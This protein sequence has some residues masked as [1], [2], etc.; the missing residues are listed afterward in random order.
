MLSLR[1]LL[2]LALIF[3]G[4]LVPAPALRAQVVT[5]KLG[6]LAPEGSA[7]HGLLKEMAE[8]WSKASDGKVKLKIYPGGVSGNE[9]DTVRKM[10]VGQLQA[11]ALS[12]VGLHDIENS[13]QAIAT[14][15]LLTS[16]D[17]WDYVYSKM[18]PVWD[19]R[20]AAKGFVPLMWGDIGWIHL[21]FKK[22]VRNPSQFKGT[23]MFAW[24][25][26]PASVEAWKMS[27]FQPV[28]ISSTD[29]LPS[30]STGMIDGFGANPPMAFLSRWY[31]HARF[32][33]SEPWGHLPIGTVV[34][35]ETWEKI[36]ADLR[37]K[38]LEIAREFGVRVNAETGKLYA[39]A[40]AQ[41]KK[42]GLKVIDLDENEKKA[43]N[44]AAEK[45][46]PAVRGGVVS[47][48]A[49]DEIKKLRDEFRA[50][51]G[52]APAPPVKK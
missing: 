48:A 40:I 38:L 5:I 23:R 51:K 42:N 30:L 35:R 22:E 8:R 27:G 31:E 12:V 18:V 20:F 17:E 6:T 10:R 14:P 19:Q 41:M 39:D 50:S 24:A 37:P 25:G 2:P 43:W 15:G 29:I 45:G 9:G 46:F 36:P 11:A 44:A 3:G 16:Q 34:A 32:M 47:E 7:W 33:P 52:K 13:A 1:R 4:F 49:F 28:V 21:F 26:D